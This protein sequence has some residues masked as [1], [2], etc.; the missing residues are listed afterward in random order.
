M[1]YR[2][3]NFHLNISLT[4]FAEIDDKCLISLIEEQSLNRELKVHTLNCDPCESGNLY[5]NMSHAA[6]IA[7]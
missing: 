4:G 7:Q 1:K 6:T 5:Q 2:W 3:L